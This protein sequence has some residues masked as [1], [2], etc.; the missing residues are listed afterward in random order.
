M[1]KQEQDGDLLTDDPGETSFSEAD[2]Q[3]SGG[4]GGLVDDASSVA[5]DSKEQPVG[6]KGQLSEDL[7][8]EKGLDKFNG[9]GAINK[10]ASA[11]LEA[12]ERLGHSV[13]LSEEPTEEELSRVH[14]LLGRPESQDGYDFSAVEIPEGR[15]ITDTQMAELKRLAFKSGLNNDQAR[16]MIQDSLARETNAIKD[17]RRVMKKQR[18]E[19]ET[20]LRS[21]LGDD[22]DKHLK[23]GKRFLQKY[24]DA[25]LTKELKDTGFGSSPAL[26]RALG[27]AGLDISE[28][29]AVR[30]E[31]PP[32]SP[33]TAHAFPVAAKMAEEKNKYYGPG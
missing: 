13:T 32:S 20:E 11:Y 4:S 12:N 22:Y 2:N 19:A 16:E 24:G 17:I 29:S 3:D 31:T 25:A 14:A 23:A 28:D 18:V 33:K 9:K 15:S 1:G 10:L 6:W 8:G 26:V 7:R 30:G 21:D 5:D 27:K